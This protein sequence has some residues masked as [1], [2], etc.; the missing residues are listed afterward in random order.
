VNE[1]SVIA[2]IARHFPPRPQ[3]YPLGI[4]DDTAILKAQLGLDLLTCDCMCEGVHFDFRWMGWGDVAYRCLSANISDIAAM[5]GEPGPFVLSLALPGHSPSVQDLEALFGGLRACVDEHH[6]QDL[7]LLGGD[8][9][10]SSG[11][12]MLSITLLGRAPSGGAVRRSTARL[13]DKLVVFRPLGGA[14]LGLELLRRGLHGRAP[15]FEREHRRPMAETSLGVALGQ[16]GLLSAMMDLS[17]G[18]VQDLERLSA[19]SGLRL[20]LEVDA[21]PRHPLLTSLCQELGLDERDFVLAGGEDYTLVATVP[22]E[23]LEALGVLLRR[24]G[25]EAYV[26]GEAFAL[27]EGVDVGAFERRGFEHFD[28]A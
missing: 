17:D 23:G 19:A 11:G 26:I 14:A 18:L 24:E 9:V 25:R 1:A 20:R 6:C 5:G 7:Y 13:G 3:L 10:R 28:S 12:L 16:S 21:I 8:T 4:G 27:G 15:L 2:M 22:V